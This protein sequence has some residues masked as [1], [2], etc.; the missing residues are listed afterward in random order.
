MLQ[1]RGDSM[2]LYNVF[3]IQCRVGWGSVSSM[4]MANGNLQELMLLK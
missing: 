1:L 3:Q 2:G 4:L